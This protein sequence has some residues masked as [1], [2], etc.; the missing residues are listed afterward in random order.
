MLIPRKFYVSISKEHTQ[1][2]V[3]GFVFLTEID[4]QRDV[5]SIFVRYEVSSYARNSPQ[6]PRE[7]IPGAPPHYYWVS[8]VC[9]E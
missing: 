2:E 8:S 6:I 7:F 3:F 4:D 9:I 5:N 1:E